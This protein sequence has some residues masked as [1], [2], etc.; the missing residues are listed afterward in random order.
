MDFHAWTYYIIQLVVSSEVVTLTRFN[1]IAP[2]CLGVF[3]LEV[4]YKGKEKERFP[5][6]PTQSYNMS[7]AEYDLLIVTD[8]TASMGVCELYSMSTGWMSL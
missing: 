4:I 8:A 6:T 5:P 1:H 7:A 3:A 2:I